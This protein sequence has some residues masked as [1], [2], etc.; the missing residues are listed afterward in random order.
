MYKSHET[1]K[2]GEIIASDYLE[3]NKYSIIE[4]NFACKI[5]EIDIIAFDLVSSEIVF[6]EVKTRTN[7]KY[8]KPKEAVNETKQKHIYRTAQ[9][10]LIKNKLEDRFV[11]IDV[12]EVYLY[13]N[14]YKINHIKQII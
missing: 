6:V 10:Y 3:K 2:E 11:R 4:R 5:G 1:G 12:I 7:I 13:K 9:Y 14:S 8:G